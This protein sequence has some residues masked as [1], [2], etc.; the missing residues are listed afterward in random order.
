[1]NRTPNGRSHTGDP[2]PQDGTGTCHDRHI[3][4]GEHLPSYS[5]TLL[6]CQ[7]WDLLDS[8]CSQERLEF[9]GKMGNY[10]IRLHTSR[11]SLQRSLA[12][13]DSGLSPG[14]IHL[15]GQGHSCKGCIRA[16]LPP[17]LHGAGSNPSH[18]FHSSHPQCCAGSQCRPLRL[19]RRLCC[20]SSPADATQPRHSN[21]PRRAHGSCRLHTHCAGPEQRAARASDCSLHSSDY[22]CPHRYGAGICIGTAFQGCQ[23]CRPPHGRC[24]HTAHRH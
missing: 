16:V 9:S 8:E 23:R 12:Y 6:Y 1:M 11:R 15:H 4:R 2:Q 7:P 14:H 5:H 21:S 22:T 17:E 18:T 20:L 19:C 3:S 13:N 10:S 24:K